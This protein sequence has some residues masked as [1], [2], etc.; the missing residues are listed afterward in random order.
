MGARDLFPET[1]LCTVEVAGGG[2]VRAQQ[3]PEGVGGGGLFAVPQGWGQ[4]SE[5]QGPLPAVEGAV[6]ASTPPLASVWLAL[7]DPGKPG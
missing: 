4:S 2:G 1:P 7:A 5:A 3:R 6:G